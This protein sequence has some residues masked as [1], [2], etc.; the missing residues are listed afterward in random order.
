MIETNR[1]GGGF[2][3]LVP[4]VVFQIYEIAD[5]FAQKS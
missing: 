4:I 2:T 1:M 5:L 3:V